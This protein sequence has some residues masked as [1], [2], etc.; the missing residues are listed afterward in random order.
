MGYKSRRDTAE[1]VLFDLERILRSEVIPK[2]KQIKE[3]QA[4]LFHLT[5]VCPHFDKI[6]DR[7][8]AYL[9]YVTRTT[10]YARNFTFRKLRLMF[11]DKNDETFELSEAQEKKLAGLY[12]TWPVSV[13]KK[14]FI[15]SKKVNGT[16][17]LTY[18][19]QGKNVESVRKEMDDNFFVILKNMKDNHDNNMKQFAKVNDYNEKISINKYIKVLEQA[20]QL[21]VFHALFSVAMKIAGLGGDL[22]II[23]G[24]GEELLSDVQL[25]SESLNGLKN[26]LD[27]IEKEAWESLRIYAKGQKEEENFSEEIFSRWKEN[28]SL[29]ASPNLEILVHEIDLMQKSLSNLSSAITRTSVSKLTN[30]ARAQIAHYKKLHALMLKGKSHVKAPGSS[31]GGQ[32]TN[33]PTYESVLTHG[34]LSTVK[35]EPKKAKVLSGLSKKR[36]ISSD[37]YMK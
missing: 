31:G 5:E 4:S 25:C 33:T 35:T 15:D 24:L 6:L 18:S 19:Y 28:Y 36:L 20:H 32:L 8:C 1:Q 2:V 14:L 3:T 30:E 37:P 9:F 12:K 34:H 11:G 27:A 7:V 21:Y 13:L 23:G 16:E 22:F 10:E 17:L 26:A 29:G